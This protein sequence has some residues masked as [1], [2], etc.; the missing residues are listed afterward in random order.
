M[1]DRVKRCWEADFI[2]RILFMDTFFPGLFRFLVAYVAEKIGGKEGNE[3]I[4]L[5]EYKKKDL[6]IE[7]IRQVSV[8]FPK[9]PST[10]PM[11][12][13]V[14]MNTVYQIEAF[15]HAMLQL[16]KGGFVPDIVIST[17]LCSQEVCNVFPAAC[18]IVYFDWYYNSMVDEFLLSRGNGSSTHKKPLHL[19]NPFQ[20]AALL[21][22]HSGIVASEVLKESYPPI[23]HDRLLSLSMGIDAKFFI[24]P[25]DGDFDTQDIRPELLELLKDPELVTWSAR[26]PNEYT[27]FRNVCLS[28]PRI[29]AARPHCKII[30]VT[31]NKQSAL[32]QQECER[33]VAMAPDRVF[34]FGQFTWNEYRA[35][36]QA[37]AVHIYMTAT[38]HLPTS[39]LEAMSCGALVL[40][41]DTKPVRSLVQHR[42]H[43]FLVDFFNPIS[44]VDTAIMVLS[45]SDDEKER[46]R[47]AA[48]NFAVRYFAAQKLIP[49]HL[50]WILKCHSEMTPSQKP[51]KPQ[52]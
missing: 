12:E 31:N 44:I 11:V 1:V 35:L 16:K 34:L 14:A 19:R 43:V 28:I 29:L 4:F 2:M 36:L 45:L 18:N 17:E 15:A 33:I 50:E 9:V 25:E 42:K 10:S 47:K 49:Q 38:P 37:S 39:M 23:F 3:I 40:A 51:A 6:S 46:V 41:S 24:P 27:G 5:S 32:E 52:L 30:M 20:L 8:R 26:N 21:G 48:R 22:C 7:N 13:Q